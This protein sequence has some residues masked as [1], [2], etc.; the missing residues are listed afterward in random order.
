MSFDDG[1]LTFSRAYTSRTVGPFTIGESRSVTRQQLA[2]LRLL[3]Q[4][5]PQLAGKEAN[6]RIALPARSGGYSIYTLTF[7]GEQLVAVKA[8]YSLFAGL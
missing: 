1:P 2:N 6:W 5:K 4:D 3:E 8:F 7:E